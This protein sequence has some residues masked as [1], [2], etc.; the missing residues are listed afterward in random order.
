M[1]IA[2]GI[3]GSGDKIN[4]T[5][6]S[7]VKLV[8]SSGYQIDVFISKAGKQ[9]LGWYKLWDRIRG[10]F[11]TVK[12]EID[13]NVPFI[14]GPLQIG[15]YD[16]L[17][18]A[19][20]TANSAAKIAYGIEDTLLTNAVAQTLKGSTPVILFPVDQFPGTVETIAPDGRVVSIR[21]RQIDL[22]NVERLRQMKGVTVVSSISEIIALV[23]E[24]LPHTD[25]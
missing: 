1:K 11:E 12:V 14:A 24:Y 4:E 15:A 13:A 20:L 21:T 5:I 9:V 8:E 10:S 25:F 3:T 22:D 16:L 2:W 7:M 23:K 18:V 17:V 6:D 19:P